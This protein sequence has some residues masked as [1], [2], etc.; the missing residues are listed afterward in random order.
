VI[1]ELT[2]VDKYLQAKP[3]PEMM[4]EEEV[5]VELSGVEKY[6]AIQAVERATGVE[7]YLMNA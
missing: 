6:M 3:E 7:K 4:Q 5:V 1:V 2:G